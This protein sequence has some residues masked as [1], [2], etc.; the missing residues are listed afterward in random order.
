MEGSGGEELF[1]VVI[2]LF[3][4]ADEGACFGFP[5]GLLPSQEFQALPRVVWEGA[6]FQDGVPTLWVEVRTGLSHKF[7][8]VERRRGQEPQKL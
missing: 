1:L 2:W 8:L 4:Q 3:G 6:R 5:R 7:V